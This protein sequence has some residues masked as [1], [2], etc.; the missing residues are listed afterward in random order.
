MPRKT[1]SLVKKSSSTTTKKRCSKGFAM[2]PMGECKSKV[3]NAMDS[4]KYIQN[5]ILKA[6][7][8][9]EEYFFNLVT[10]S[11]KK[12]LIKYL[13][14]I[15]KLAEKYEKKCK[16]IAKQL[17]S[18]GLP[19]EQS[20]SLHD[21]VDAMNLLKNIKENYDERNTTIGALPTIGKN[22]HNSIYKY[23]IS[24]NIKNVEKFD[25]DADDPYP[26]WVRCNR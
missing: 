20:S 21:F 4:L 19:T 15:D 26:D 23:F 1:T 22:I 17:S 6:I 2:D 13:K 11:G 3:Q 7:E 9:S 24:P 10:E 14:N 25:L 5:Q 16:T 12:K 8:N 18:R